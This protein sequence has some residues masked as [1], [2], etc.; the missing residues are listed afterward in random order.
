VLLGSGLCDW[1]ITH[2]EESYGVVCL[3]VIVKP[4]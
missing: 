4:G 2:P 3:S 1:P